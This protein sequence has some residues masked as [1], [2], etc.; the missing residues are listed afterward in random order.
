MQ[1]ND[2]GRAGHDQSPSSGEDAQMQRQMERHMQPHM[3][4]MHAMHQFMLWVHFANMV[5]GAWLIFSPMALAYTE[6]AN[7]GLGTARVTAERMLAPTK[8]RMHWLMWSDIISGVLIML[9]STLALCWK[10]RW[11]QWGKVAVA[12]WL[13][14]APLLF[15]AP[16]AGALASATLVAALVVA[17]SIVVPRM[18]GMSMKSMMD[19]S[20]IPP[21][22]DDSPSAWSQRLPIIALALPQGP[23]RQR[24]GGWNRYLL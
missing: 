10:C 12:F 3:Q 9:L 13:L 19:E 23:V 8:Q 14:G 15:W 21:G 6:L 24:Y 11:A 1:I 22:R 20:V 18:P 4:Q 16:H 7:F 17:F 2:S 5:L